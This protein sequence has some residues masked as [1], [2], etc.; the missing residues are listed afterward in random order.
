M[1]KKSRRRRKKKD[2]KDLEEN[3]REAGATEII[4]IYTD[5]DKLSAVK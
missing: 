1:K 4:I 3:I 5:G 2:E